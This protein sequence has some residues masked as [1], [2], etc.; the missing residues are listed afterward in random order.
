MRRSSIYTLSAV[1]WVSALGSSGL[2][3]SEPSASPEV[4]LASWY[5]DSM[6]GKR[7]AS[8]ER[9]NKLALTAAHRTLPLG[10]YVMVENLRNGRSVR[11]KI[12]DRGP[13]HRS[14]VIDV[15]RAAAERLHFIQQG[16][17]R[18]SITP[19]SP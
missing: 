4:G 1:F 19:E 3:A 5:A 16:H 2:M 12:N 14:R 8:G 17:T 9:Y 6:Q 10:T 15:S 13:F 7:T 11:V 18:V